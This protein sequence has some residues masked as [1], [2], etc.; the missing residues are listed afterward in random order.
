M[1]LSELLKPLDVFDQLK[2]SKLSEWL[3]LAAVAVHAIAAIDAIAAVA[4][5]ATVDV[6]SAMYCYCSVALSQPLTPS[7]VLYSL[8]PRIIIAV[9][10]SEGIVL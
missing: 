8:K 6:I 3:W 10:L 4:A 2:P 9:E 5:M 7:R 1:E